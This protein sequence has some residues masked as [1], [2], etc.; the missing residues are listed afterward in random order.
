LD[1]T[2]ARQR[3]SFADMQA[4]IDAL[5]A[6]LREAR[7]QKT[8]T[9]EVLGVINASPGD[10]AAVFDAMLVKATALCEA[11]FGILLTWDGECFHRVAWHGVS[12]ELMGA[13]GEV[14]RPAPGSLSYRI[15][16]G[17]NLISVV[18]MRAD[19]HIAGAPVRALVRVGGTRSFVAVAL[20]K[21]DA[22]LGQLSI[23]RQ[24]V[25]PFTD[26]EIALL[27][28]FAAQAVVAMENA[29][30]LGELR[31]RNDEVA[32]LN[33]SLEARVAEQSTNWAESGGSNVSWRRNWPS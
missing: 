27:Q 23:Y 4:R 28:N 15:V 5:E 12:P 1:A 18:D 30:L 11:A 21:D 6:E 13:L 2:G 14:N 31:Q 26:K 9:G 33:R 32:E 22:L 20:R 24:E 8:A 7:D 19:G 17:E 29:R 10:L 3:P 16:Q 25:R